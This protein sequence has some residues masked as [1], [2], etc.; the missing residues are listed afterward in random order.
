MVLVVVVMTIMMTI[1]TKTMM[2]VMTRMTMAM[3]PMRLTM[4]TS[5]TREV[6]MLETM[7]GQF[8]LARKGTRPDTLSSNWDKITDSY[9]GSC[10]TATA[11]PDLLNIPHI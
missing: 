6:F 7:T 2:M 10:R 5:G 11:T 3:T 1:I 8:W 4:T 9:S